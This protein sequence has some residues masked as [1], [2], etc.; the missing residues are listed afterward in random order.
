MSAPAKLEAVYPL[1]PMQQGML[2]HT[3][4]DPGSGA[5]VVQL[6]CRLDGPLDR[7]ALRRAWQAVVDHHPALRTAFPW[8][9]KDRPLQAV[10]PRA[11]VP[12]A[13]EDWRAFDSS[14]QDG[15]LA[16]LL[17]EDRRRGFDLKKAPLLRLTLIRQ[18]EERHLLL[19][20]S[21]HL[22]LDGW[23][24]AQVLADVTAAYAD[25]I[26]D[27]A[28]HLEPRRPFRDFVTWLGRKDAAE[29]EAFWRRALEGY[30]GAVPIELPRS[31]PSEDG[32]RFAEVHSALSAADARAVRGLASAC[33]LTENAVVLGAFC[34]LVAHYADRPSAAVGVTVSGRPPELEGVE[35]MVGLFI[36]TL[37]FH[38]EVEEGAT[39]AAWL[40]GLQE[41]LAALQ[42][43]SWVPLP[44][45][46]RWAGLPADQPL[47]EPL[48]VFENYPE[49]GGP[50][51]DLGGLRLGEVAAV[52]QPDSP[53]TLVAAP[54]G[55]D[56]PLGLR[57]IFDRRR[58]AEPAVERLLGHL[59]NLLRAMAA[60]PQARLGDLSLL[61]PD[62]ETQLLL[63]GRG[64]R[65][66][67]PRDANLADL[68]EE[69]A[70]RNPEA[71]AVV[72][73]D[74]CLTYGDLDRRADLLSRELDARGV[75]PGD[76]V[77]VI[78]ER[79]ADFIVAV[80]GILKSGA[81]YVPLD[82]GYPAER[83][84][85]MLEDAGGVGGDSLRGPT[86]VSGKSDRPP[87]RS[88]T[89]LSPSP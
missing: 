5:Y 61:A 44:E 16:A 36:N 15:R 63:E 78:L 28:P 23:S 69:Q 14:E 76:R 77:A 88:L 52:E 83:L 10:L 19:W 35:R 51:P 38:T 4:L 1:T 79:G 13:E 39:V 3:L 29:A 37:P 20:T 73:G 12:W 81:A 72:Q 17:D 67:Y 85:F 25:L 53:L 58:F 54:A 45:V 22:L 11:E 34:L 48:F 65:P 30:P 56:D 7:G 2:F 70:K 18:A 27:R 64:A 46:R 71:P 62:E 75:R 33:R 9:R 32:P 42:P 50:V 57:A 60:A 47:F 68:F 82:P 66:T 89:P 21:H 55:A 43:Y 6:P 74:Q 87:L 86:R 41:R 31:D 84:A 59:E 24:S 8:D 26:Q 49:A 40:A 80:L